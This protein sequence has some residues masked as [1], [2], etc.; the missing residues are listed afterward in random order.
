MEPPS[1]QGLGSTAWNQFMVWPASIQ[2][3][4]TLGVSTDLVVSCAVLPANTATFKVSNIDII[5]I[6][7]GTLTQVP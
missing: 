2:G 4:V 7:L 5:A 6:K 3:S 1:I